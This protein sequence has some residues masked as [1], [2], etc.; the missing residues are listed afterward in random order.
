VKA[1][2]DAGVWGRLFAVGWLLKKTGG[3]RRVP[4]DRCDCC[5]ADG[6]GVRGQRERSWRDR[7]GWLVLRLVH[8]SGARAVGAARGVGAAGPPR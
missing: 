7:C 4:D 6:D 1:F 3:L 8:A 5:C 2:I